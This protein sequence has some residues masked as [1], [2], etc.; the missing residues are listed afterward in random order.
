VIRHAMLALPRPAGWKDVAEVA[1]LGDALVLTEAG[2]AQLSV[3]FDGA[4]FP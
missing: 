4:F 1:V 2:G 3:G